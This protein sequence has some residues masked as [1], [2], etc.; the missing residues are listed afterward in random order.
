MAMYYLHSFVRDSDGNPY[1]SFDQEL[2][3]ERRQSGDDAMLEIENGFDYLAQ[4]DDERIMIITTKVVDMH[5][6]FE[7]KFRHEEI[8][9]KVKD[10]RKTHPSRYSWKFYVN[11]AFALIARFMIFVGQTPGSANM[12]IPLIKAP[13]CTDS[14]FIE[15]IRRKRSDYGG[16]FKDVSIRYTSSPQGGS[17]HYEHAL[18][19]EKLLDA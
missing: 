17:S 6:E 12:M 15:F 5:T 4:L 14:E 2:M 1:G 16:V 7:Y 9:Q 18:L 13:G 3:L 10:L 11:Q 19:V 8:T